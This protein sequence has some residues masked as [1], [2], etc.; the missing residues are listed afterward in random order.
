M[1]AAT[2]FGFDSID[3]W[4]A[5][6]SVVVAFMRFAKKRSRSGAIAPS[7][8]ETTYQDGLLFHAT[9]NTLLPKAETLMG[10]WVAATTRA[11]AGGRSDAKCLTTASMGRVMKPC[12]STIGAASAGGAGYGLPRSPITS[13]A[14]GPKAA[15]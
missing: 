8:V 7:S 5:V 3:T 10:P 12:A 13:P 9:L 1:T 4:L 11:S 6:N 14:S 15:T 2:S